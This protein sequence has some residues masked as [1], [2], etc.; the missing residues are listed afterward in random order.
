MRSVADLFRRGIGSGIG[1]PL[2]PGHGRLTHFAEQPHSGALLFWIGDRHRAEQ[3]PGM[4]SRN[5]V[6]GC[7][8][9]ANSCSRDAT[10]TIRPRYIT[11]ISC[12]DVP[13][14]AEIVG[15][16]QISKPKFALQV[17]Q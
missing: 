15:D 1:S 12:R 5:R 10:S 14:N 4:P 2:M 3:Q 17:P 9:V 16:E 13:D 11:P 8:G 7:C 6:Y